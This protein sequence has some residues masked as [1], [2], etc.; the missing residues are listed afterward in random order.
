MEL[1]FHSAGREGLSE[2]SAENRWLEKANVYRVDSQT[3][4]MIF[5]KPN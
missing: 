5:T 4:V 1:E 3:Q 2:G